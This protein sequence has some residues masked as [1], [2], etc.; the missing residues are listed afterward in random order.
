MIEIV[1]G[2]VGMGKDETHW[3]LKGGA[4]RASEFEG[5][6]GIA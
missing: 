4:D 2:S 5:V 6:G 1:V 3:A